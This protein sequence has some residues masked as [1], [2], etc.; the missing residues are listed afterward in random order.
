MDDLEAPI[1]KLDDAY[2]DIKNSIYKP[3]RKSKPVRYIPRE[4]SREYMENIDKIV[5]SLEELQQDDRLLELE[6]DMEKITKKL[7]ES[8]PLDELKELCVEILERRI[9]YYTILLHSYGIFFGELNTPNIVF[10]EIEEKKA[11][12]K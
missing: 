5:K 6:E 8:K 3:K 1:E 9:H 11:T 10:Q 4:E 12:C 2:D 7:D